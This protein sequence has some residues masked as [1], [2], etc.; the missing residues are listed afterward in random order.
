MSAY[1]PLALS[2][3]PFAG[4]KEQVGVAAFDYLVAAHELNPDLAGALSRLVFRPDYTNWVDTEPLE[5]KS[6]TLAELL[7]Q[8]PALRIDGELRIGAELYQ[9]KLFCYDLSPSDKRACLE[10][11]IDSYAYQAVYD[12]TPEDDDAHDEVAHAGLLGLC[13]G[14]ADAVKPDA[15]M[16][17]F[18][19]YKL[20]PLDPNDVLARLRKPELTPRGRRPGLVTGVRA[21]LLPRAEVEKVWGKG[22]HIIEDVGGYVI[23]DSL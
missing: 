13:S 22:A 4:K 10:V 9:S 8:H 6:K 12:F 3:T 19:D 23:L 20:G 1:T 7:A 21:A 11:H 17:R 15:F 5:P 16:L 18:D 14:L 2:F